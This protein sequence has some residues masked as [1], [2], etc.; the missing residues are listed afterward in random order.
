MK[1]IVDDIRVPLFSQPLCQF[2][3]HAFVVRGLKVKTRC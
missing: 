1:H 3:D 2:A